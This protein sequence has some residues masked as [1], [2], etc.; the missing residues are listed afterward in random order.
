M[1]FPAVV[2]LAMGYSEFKFPSH[3]KALSILQPAALQAPRK[4]GVQS[5]RSL[6]K[7]FPTHELDPSK[8][9]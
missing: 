7:A 5:V 4:A 6:T 3:R 2:L 9:E 8:A 1:D